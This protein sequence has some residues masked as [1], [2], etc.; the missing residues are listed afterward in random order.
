MNAESSLQELGRE[1]LEAASRPEEQQAGDGEGLGLL[2][3]VAASA[4][5]KWDKSVSRLQSIFS[6]SLS[7]GS[8]WFIFSGPLSSGCFLGC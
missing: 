4:K 1:T 5:H 2:D 3:W 6:Q 7:R 8:L